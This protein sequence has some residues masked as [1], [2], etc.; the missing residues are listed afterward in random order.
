MNILGT[1]ASP[2]KASCRKSRKQSIRQL[3]MQMQHQQQAQPQ[4]VLPL[5]TS[6]SEISYSNASQELSCKQR[7]LRSIRIRCI[8]LTL[9]IAASVTFLVQK[10]GYAG[11]NSPWSVVMPQPKRKHF[12][13]VV[14]MAPTPKELRQLKPLLS[15]LIQNQGSFAPA[16]VY[17][18]LP[19]RDQDGKPYLYKIPDFVERYIDQKKIVVLNQNTNFGNATKLYALMS[20]ERSSISSRILYMDANQ[21]A[22]PSNYISHFSAQSEKFPNAALGFQGAKLTSYFRSLNVI[23]NVKEPVKV[24]ILEG[25]AIMVQRKFFDVE[26][27]MELAEEAPKHVQAA[28]KFM[29]AA[30]LEDQNV[31]RWVV[32]RAATVSVHYMESGRPFYVQCGFYLQQQLGIWKSFRFHNYKRLT[33]VEKDALRCDT[34]DKKACQPGYTDVLKALDRKALSLKR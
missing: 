7:I 29:I 34:G 33:D 19:R 17:L 9:L 28:D 18:V 8:V 13:V 23:D 24:D 2:S 6:T 12:R 11:L 31:E 22:L 27:F 10:R 30:H 16:M 32:P 3:Q 1:S 15:S 21:K 25:S 20:W 4:F 14:T 5:T 26:A